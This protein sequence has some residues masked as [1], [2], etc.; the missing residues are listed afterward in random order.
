M[1]K[2]LLGIDQRHLDALATAQVVPN[3]LRCVQCGMCSYNCPL[4][5]DVRA[6]CR[7]GEPIDNNQ[8]LSCGECIRHC[9]R[10]ALSFKRSSIFR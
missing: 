9:P 7:T 5:L 2:E 10:G 6:H 4:G 3:P 8:C 1:L